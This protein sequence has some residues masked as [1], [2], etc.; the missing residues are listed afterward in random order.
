MKISGSPGSVKIFRAK[1]I[2]TFS[3]LCGKKPGR[4]ICTAHCADIPYSTVP[5]PARTL[6]HDYSKKENCWKKRIL[7]GRIY[8]RKITNASIM[9][10]RPRT[11]GRGACCVVAGIVVCGGWAVVSGAAEAV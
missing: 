6:F 3:F 10:A 7:P 9:A 1:K 4:K 11:A 2:R 5:A 8:F